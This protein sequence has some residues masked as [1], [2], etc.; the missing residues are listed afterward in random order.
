[1]DI[2][3]KATHCDDLSYLVARVRCLIDIPEHKSCFTI[4]IDNW[5]IGNESKYIFVNLKPMFCISGETS[6]CKIHDTY[7]VY[8]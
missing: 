8:K 7:I 2:Y 4:P 6:M 1:M 5:H 3:D